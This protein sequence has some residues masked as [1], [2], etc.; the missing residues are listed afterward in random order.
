MAIR[1]IHLELTTTDDWFIWDKTMIIFIVIKHITPYYNA[2][3]IID[4]SHGIKGR[5]VPIGFSFV[6]NES[7]NAGLLLT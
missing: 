5:V 4:N 3:S 2:S 1:I 7:T 6:V